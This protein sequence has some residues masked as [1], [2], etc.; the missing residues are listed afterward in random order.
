MK[1]SLQIHGE[2]D[3]RTLLVQENLA[4]VLLHQ[5]QKLDEAEFIIRGV[6]SKLMVEPGPDDALTLKT[7]FLLA[8]LIFEN[9]RIRE[10]VELTERILERQRDSLGAMHPDTKAT[11]DVLERI[12]NMP[13][14]Q[15]NK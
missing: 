4:K 9:G 13:D 6:L 12:R 11:A 5:H 8:Q 14:D 7:Q 1:T 3:F 15:I 2:S 10:S